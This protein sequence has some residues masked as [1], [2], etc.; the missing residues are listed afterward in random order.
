MTTS[1]HKGVWLSDSPATIGEGASGHIVLSVE[2]PLEIVE[3]DEWPQ[4]GTEF[5]EFLVRAGVLYEF[6]V[7]G[8]SVASAFNVDFLDSDEVLVYG[9]N[10]GKGF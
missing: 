3:P 9:V 7:G 10:I 1:T 5:R 4:E 6:E 8:F 2:I